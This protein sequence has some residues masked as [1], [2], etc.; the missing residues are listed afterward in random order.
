MKSHEA[1]AEKEAEGGHVLPLAGVGRA[2]PAEGEASNWRGKSLG[3]NR[4]RA[5]G[6]FQAP[7]RPWG[8][9]RKER[10]KVVSGGQ[11]FP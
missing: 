6:P 11:A 10:R 3:L 7:P 1:V 2:G 9:G 5:Q 8:S 4:M